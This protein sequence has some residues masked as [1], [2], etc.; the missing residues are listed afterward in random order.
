MVASQVG[1]LIGGLVVVE[2]SC[3]T[4]RASAGC[5]I[6]AAQNADFPLLAGAVLVV[7]VAFQVSMLLADLAYAWLNPRIRLGGME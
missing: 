5:S 4:I 1:Y 6:D 3:S 2:T 7:A